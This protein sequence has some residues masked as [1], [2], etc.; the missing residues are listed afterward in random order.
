MGSLIV[1][2]NMEE[3]GERSFGLTMGAAC[4]LLAVYSLWRGRAGAAGLFALVALGL[5]VFALGAPSLLRVPSAL[6]RGFAHAL[7]WFNTR[8][9]LSAMFFLILTPVGIV[10]RLMRWDPL[11]RR[12]KGTATGWVPYSARQRDPKH[13]ERMY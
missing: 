10:V 8:V 6:W 2:G 9:L 5:V 13:Y 3:R 1:L 11:G 4:G 12:R 7:A